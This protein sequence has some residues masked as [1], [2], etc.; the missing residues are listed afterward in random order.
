[1]KKI[2]IGVLAL[3][4]IALGG[5]IIW[6]SQKSGP[7]LTRIDAVLPEGAIV[8]VRS[9][10]FGQQLTKLAETKAW[11]NF[12]EKNLWQDFFSKLDL[13]E[14]DYEKMRKMFGQE[15]AVA[16]Y[17][18]G[19]TQLDA[20][21]KVALASSVFFVTRTSLEVDPEEFFA[22]VF[23]WFQ[24][25]VTISRENYRG[26]TITYV[27]PND[28]SLCI[29]Y[30]RIKDLLVFGFGG[31]AVKDCIDVVSQNKKSLAQDP[32]YGKAQKSFASQANVTGFVS[33][34]KLVS[35]IRLAVAPFFEKQGQANET[36]RQK[37][38]DQL[39]RVEN[40]KVLAF[41]AEAGVPESRFKS[42]LF[43]DPAGLSEDARKTYACSARKN[44]TLTFISSDVLAYQWSPCYDFGQYW[45]ASK[46][47][48]KRKK[49]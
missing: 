21:G 8:Y 19:V 23:Q 41:S 40:F 31:W 16:A 4:I 35:Q 1:M 27:S 49:Q 43:F 48:I 24:K 10:D 18:A 25:G 46:K 42:I 15:F 38:E 12:Q 47:Q 39:H 7:V 20:Q 30:V 33:G 9:L 32:L 29:S 3:A 17:P 13:S 34:E 14:L 44:K 37:I 6:Q 26:L 2:L 11:K 5:V 45:E 22:Q 28:G 36:L